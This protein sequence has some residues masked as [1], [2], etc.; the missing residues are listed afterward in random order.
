MF[1]PEVMTTLPTGSVDEVHRCER[2][3]L[4]EVTY[5]EEEGFNAKQYEHTFLYTSRIG[6][7]ADLNIVSS[8]SEVLFQA[9]DMTLLWD[10]AHSSFTGWILGVEGGHAYTEVSPLQSAR[11]GQVT[12]YPLATSSYS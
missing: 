7:S 3:I 5:E 9:S 4:V 8:D 2:W 12:H 6:V 11:H 1:K 10:Y